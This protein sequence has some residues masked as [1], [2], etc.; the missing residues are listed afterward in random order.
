MEIAPGVH[1]LTD[2]KGSYAYLVLGSEPVLID[3]SM[4]GRAQAILSEL[5]QLGMKPTDLAHILLTHQDPDHIGNAKELKAL[6]GAVLWAP[7]TEV[8]F[9]HGDSKPP[10]LRRVIRQIVRVNRPQIDRT[11]QPGEKIG[12]LEVI[13]APGHTVGHTCLLFHD[14]LLAGDLVTSSKGKLKRAPGFLTWDRTALESSLRTVGRFQFS[15]VCPA[16]G[17]PV[18][19]GSLW[20][21]LISP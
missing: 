17:E 20:E 19:R 10:G 16:H 2:T 7:E 18:Q 6:S 5:G 21:A 3:T 14:V 9:I 11:Y 15:W 1:L 12:G 4:P 8:P 13:P